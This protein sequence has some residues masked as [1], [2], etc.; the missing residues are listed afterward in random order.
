MEVLREMAPFAV[1]LV[2]PPVLFVIIPRNWQG[3]LRFWAVY[4]S[5]LILGVLISF[6]MGE[7]L[8]DLPEAIVAIVLDSSLVFAASQVGYR[9]F[10]KGL[11]ESRLAKTN[12][13]TA[14]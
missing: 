10:W 1:G 2:L 4:A 11:I 7:L 14:K 13:S 5:A 6:F 3:A 8:V 12:V 9:L